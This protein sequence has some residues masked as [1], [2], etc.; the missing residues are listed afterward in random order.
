MGA[1]YAI[2]DDNESFGT[3]LSS[4][5]NNTKS[6]QLGCEPS[7]QYEIIGLCKSYSSLQWFDFITSPD[8][9]YSLEIVNDNGP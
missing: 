1:G 7:F 8:L 4:L 3:K 6:I 9:N 2:Q 5:R